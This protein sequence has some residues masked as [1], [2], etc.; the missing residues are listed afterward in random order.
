MNSF[1]DS[2]CIGIHIFAGVLG[3][4]SAVA[5]FLIV[6]AC[7]YGIVKSFKKGEKK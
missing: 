7:V 5:V 2:Y 3:F 6:F 1:M 4:V